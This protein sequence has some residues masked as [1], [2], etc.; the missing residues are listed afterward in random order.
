MSAGHWYDGLDAG[1]REAHRVAH[2]A[3]RSKRRQAR[4]TARQRASSYKADDPDTWASIDDPS[5]GS[6]LSSTESMIARET[7]PKFL[8]TP[9][10]ALNVLFPLSPLFCVVFSVFSVY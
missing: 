8:V 10:S 6:S 7:F 9:A 3:A 1:Q 2:A 4:A 5:S